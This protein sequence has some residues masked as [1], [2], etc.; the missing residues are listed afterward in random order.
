MISTTVSPGMPAIAALMAPRRKQETG[1]HAR[2]RA[3]ARRAVPE[4]AAT[5]YTTP[6][7]FKPDKVSSDNPSNSASTSF[8]PS[9][10]VGGAL[11]TG[12]RSPSKR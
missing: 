10:S 11:R 5:Y 4:I 2:R 12:K 8:V 6:R 7:S 3:A 1:T 9:P